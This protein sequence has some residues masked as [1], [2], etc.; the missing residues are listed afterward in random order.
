MLFA[1]L[2]I[3]VM[4]SFDLKTTE[5]RTAKKTLFVVLLI[6]MGVGVIQEGLQLLTGA[7]ILQWNTLLDLGVDMAGTLLGYWVLLGVRKIRRT[8]SPPVTKSRA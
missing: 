8:H 4:V 7:P 2:T 5:P 6:S 1:G 3:L